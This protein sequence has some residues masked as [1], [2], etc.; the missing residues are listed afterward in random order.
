ARAGEAGRG[1]AVVADEVRKL[2]EKTMLATTEVAD[3]IRDI[4]GSTR[5]VVTGMD[6]TK[7]K[8]ELTA[9]MAE[10]SGS[11]LQQIVDQSDRIA[12]MVRNIAA[13][14]E[15]Q[16]STSDEVNQSVSH[17]NELSQDISRQIQ[18][19]NQR[20]AGVRDLSQHLAALVERFRE[21]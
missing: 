12:D 8:V 4:Q 13:A 16:S 10:K 19:A 5:T 7:A 2:A 21:Q 18:E 9:D 17:I 11:V 20:I 14:S 3:A 1:F 6:E 15:Q